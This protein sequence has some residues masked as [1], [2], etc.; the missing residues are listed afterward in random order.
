ME[1]HYPFN[2]IHALDDSLFTKFNK[3]DQCQYCWHP[4]YKCL[5][6]T[7]SQPYWLV[8]SRLAH[9]NPREIRGLAI[10]A[11]GSQFIRLAGLKHKVRSQSGNG[12]YHVGVNNFPEWK[13]AYQSPLETQAFLS[14]NAFSICKKCGSDKL[15][16]DSVPH[17]KSEDV[18]RHSCKGRWLSVQQQHW[19]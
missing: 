3:D 8:P 12:S 14:F 11:W 9:D 15:V 13:C 6:A 19:L 17:N 5:Y 7:W 16:K 1:S 18:E 10:F 2:S 4:A